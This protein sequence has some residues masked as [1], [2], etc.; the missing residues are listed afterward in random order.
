MTPNFYNQANPLLSND[1]VMYE[2]RGS[3]NGVDG[4]LQNEWGQVIYLPATLAS[5]GSALASAT[6]RHFPDPQMSCP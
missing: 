2:L 5:D 1:A 6:T 3:I 4:T